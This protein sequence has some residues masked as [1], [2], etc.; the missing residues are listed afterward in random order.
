MIVISKDRRQLA[1]VHYAGYQLEFTEAKLG[2]THGDRSW[3]VGYGGINGKGLCERCRG[4]LVQSNYSR[5]W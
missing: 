4:P 1:D 5:R 2:G 3:V